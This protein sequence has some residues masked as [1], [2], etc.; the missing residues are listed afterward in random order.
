MDTNFLKDMKK[1]SILIV[2]DDEITLS[3]L[4]DTLK[5]F[6]HTVY[7]AKDG[8]EALKTYKSHKSNIDIL[9]L[10]IELP[11]LSGIEVVKQIRKEDLIISIIFLTNFEKIEYLKAS[12]KLNLIDYVI[13]PLSLDKL[14]KIMEEAINY[15]KQNNRIHCKI[16]DKIKY[17]FLNKTI[18]KDQIEYRLSTT[19]SLCLELFIK[20]RT[21][22]VTNQMIEHELCEYYEDNVNFIKNLIYKIRGKLGK[23][24]ILNIK[25]TGYVLL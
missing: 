10:D 25:N 22:V 24:T 7:Y 15:L 13:K 6:F 16:T 23:D 9:I 8:E 4:E 12:I 14:F 5:V 20:N 11:K 2:E 18:E 21:K 1:L 3:N 19:E 17:N